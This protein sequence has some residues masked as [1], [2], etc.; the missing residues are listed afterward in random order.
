MRPIFSIPEHEIREIYHMIIDPASFE[1]ILDHLNDGL[2]IV[3][4]D[5]KVL[6]W[7]QAAERIS[8][9]SA[10]EVV[11]KHCH[12]NILN[13]VDSDGRQLCFTGCP[14]GATIEDGERREGEIY[15]HH[16]AGHRVPVSVRV[17]QLT[18]TEGIVIGGI[19]LFT[20]ISNRAASELRVQELEKLALLDHLTQLAN[21]TH[22]EN[23]IEIRIEEFRRYRVPFGI[24]FIDMDHF[25]ELND[26]HGHTGGDE[27]LRFAG[28]T[29]AA[30]SRPFDLYGRWGGEEFVGI[31]RSVTEKELKMLGNR[32]RTLIEQS[33]VLH[34]EEKL[35]VT[36]SIGATLV[37]DGDDAK[38]LVHRADMLMYQSKEAGR[39]CLTFG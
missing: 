13:H 1:R 27:V 23:E 35:Q 7:N 19:E 21:R 20:D 32:I 34:G 16:K 18:D 9:F 15:M 37:K 28:R 5:R 6:Y 10:E 30:N 31:I 22:L 29:F 39:N 14:L 33:F 17:S 25:K 26:T 12:D 11:G 4:C 2:Y 24:L 38:R 36:I 8:G 3:D